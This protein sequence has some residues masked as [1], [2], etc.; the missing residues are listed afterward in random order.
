VVQIDDLKNPANAADY[1]VITNDMMAGPAGGQPGCVP[2]LAHRR[3]G[4]SDRA[5]WSRPRNIYAWYSNGRLDPTAIRNFLYDTVRG[6][7]WSQPP[8]FV[9]FLGD[10]SYDF[11]ELARS[12]G[13]GRAHELGAR[14]I[15]TLWATAQFSTDDWLVDLDLGLSDPYPGGAFPGDSVLWM[16][17]D[18]ASGP[19]AGEQRRRRRLPGERQGDPVRSAALVRRM[20]TPRPHAGGRR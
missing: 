14:P 12:R 9:C 2:F 11:Q 13:R 20:A 6:V 18:F 7:G 3:R 19:P 4:E 10:A 16:V 8:T 1:V 5:A 17:P 15:P